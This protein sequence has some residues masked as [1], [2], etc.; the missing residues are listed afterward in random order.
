MVGGIGTY[1]KHLLAGVS[2]FQSGIDIHAITRQEHAK[3]VAGWCSQV[4]IIEVSIYTLLEQLAIPRAAKGCDLLHIPHYNAPLLHRGPLVISIHDI[5]HIT[6]PAYRQSYKAWA[7][8]RPILQLVTQKA[9]HIITVSEYSKAEIVERLG[10]PASKVT[11]IYNGVSDEF[12]CKDRNAAVKTVSEALRLHNPYILY[13][14][15][16]KP[17]KNVTTLLQAFARLHK[18]RD[19][20]HKL[21]IVGDDARWKKSLLEER[22]RLG[23]DAATVLVSHVPEVLLPSVYAAADLLV[24]PSRIEGFGLPVLEAMASGTPVISSRAASLPEVAGEAALYFDPGSPEELADT[25]E[26]LLNSRELQETL[27]VK[28]LERVKKF[29]WRHSAWKHVELYRRLLTLN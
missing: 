28:G 12:R 23:I 5:I 17:Y 10:V 18:C 19:I 8:A 4:Q 1:I 16:L 14:G 25:L 22:S 6:D 13:V 2:E 24:M 26:R 7:Y 21:L 9:Q 27:R 29:T 15:S 3:L 11:T 20:P